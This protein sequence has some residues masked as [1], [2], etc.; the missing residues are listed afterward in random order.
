MKFLALLSPPWATMQPKGRALCRRSV[1]RTCLLVG[2]VLGDRVRQQRH[3]SPQCLPCDDVFPHF[4]RSAC[5][6][7][8]RLSHPL[9]PPSSA[10]TRWRAGRRR[11]DPQAARPTG[12]AAHAGFPPSETQPTCHGRAALVGHVA[13]HVHAPQLL[14]LEV[15]PRQG[16]SHRGREALRRRQRR[17]RH[18]R[19]RTTDHPRH[20]E[21][22]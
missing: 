22:Q 5:Q 20:L 12:V 4:R 15:H 13:L 14:H 11:G 3:R 21:Q 10:S 19:V 8:R 6:G 17:R 9:V 16:R 1:V 18:R 2:Q 7:H